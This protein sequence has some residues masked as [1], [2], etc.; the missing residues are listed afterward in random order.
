[1]GG[2]RGQGGE[3]DTKIGR[4]Y[5]L[6]RLERRG[7]A[8][9]LSLDDHQHLSGSVV[10]EAVA[11]SV[12]SLFGG[13]VVREP[14]ALAD[15]LPPKGDGCT[16]DF[17]AVCICDHSMDMVVIVGWGHTHLTSNSRAEPRLAASPGT[18]RAISHVHCCFSVSGQN[19]P[20]L[21]GKVGE[22]NPLLLEALKM[23]LSSVSPKFAGCY[24]LGTYKCQEPNP[25]KS[26]C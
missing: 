5:G 4:S 1:M 17:L 19:Q 2:I 21:F 10:G 6:G 13:A 24:K 22:L 25:T 16:G 26:K 18:V 14:D 8:A 3:V 12:A 7:E 11:E 9:A 20:K 15:A 23:P